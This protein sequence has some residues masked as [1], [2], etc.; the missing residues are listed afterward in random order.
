MERFRPLFLTALL[1]AAAACSGGDGGGQ[2]AKPVAYPRDDSLRVDQIQLLT[3]HNSYHQRGSVRLPGPLGD[4][5]DYAHLPLDQQLEEQG[6]R[7]FEIDIAYDGSSFPVVHTPVVDAN[8][9]CSPFLDCLETI[10]G[11]SDDHPGHAPI[12]VLVEPKDGN[13]E[14]VLDP[15]LQPFDR[16]VLDRLDG[17]IRSVFEPRDLLAPDDVRGG[18]RTLRAAVVDRGWPTMAEARGKVVFV[19]NRGGGIRDEYLQGRPSLEGAPM[20]V[21]AE[22]DAPSAAVVKVDDPD[23]A[24]I[25]ELVRDHFIVRTRADADLAEARSNDTT[26]RGRALRSGAQIV[27][28]DF[29]VP[30]P[31]INA[32]YFVQLPGGKPGRCNPVQAPRRC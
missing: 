9:N 13:L 18:R 2:E 12:F 26:R 8:S 29:P 23:V 15:R 14:R 17:E 20:F 6:V 25:Q 32:E 3:T 21:T 1:V 28:T 4:E 30:V 5:L 22:P 7:G 10:K 11:W 19:L 24:L 27:S 16:D 31:S